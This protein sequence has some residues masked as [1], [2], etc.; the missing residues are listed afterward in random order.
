MLESIKKIYEKDYKK[1]LLI[2]IIVLI[3]ALFQL[4]YQTATTGDFIIKD[5]TLKGGVKATVFTED[6]YDTSILKSDLLNEFENSQIIIKQKTEQYIIDAGISDSQEIAKFAE[7]IENFFHVAND[8][9]NI[10]VTG[11]SLGNSFFKDIIKAIIIAFVFMGIV[12]FIYFRTLVPSFAIILA[13]FSDMVVTLAIVNLLGIPLSMGGIIALLLLIGYSVD[14]DIL[15]TTRTLKNKDKP[16]M[17]N[18]YSALKTG[19]T[20]NITTLCAVSVALIFSK[21]EVISQIMLILFIGL[22]VDM[23]NTWIQNVGI[24]RLYLENHKNK[25]KG[26]F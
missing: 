4:G 20:M 16:V 17:E 6:L 1:I 11:S 9:L 24:L 2:P 7:I 18:V 19:L 22:F 25:S 21:S 8:K 13:A 10:E 26:E 3:L 5:I 12:V 23:L 15:L 14:T